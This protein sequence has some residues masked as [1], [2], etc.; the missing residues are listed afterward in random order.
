MSTASSITDEPSIA[1]LLRLAIETQKPQSFLTGVFELFRRCNETYV[2][3]R[4]CS[5][6]LSQALRLSTIGAEEF[7]GR[8]RD[9]IGSWAPRNNHKVSE[10]RMVNSGYDLFWTL[11][12]H[13]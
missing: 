11:L 13:A 9:G 4:P 5:D 8:V 7:D 1:F 12:S 3:G 10:K 2:F 6:L